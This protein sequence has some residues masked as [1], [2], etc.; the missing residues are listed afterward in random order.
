MANIFNFMSCKYAPTVAEGLEE[1]FEG[2]N[3]PEDFFKLV[4]KVREAVEDAGKAF[5]KSRYY[6]DVE[7]LDFLAQGILLMEACNFLAKHQSPWS[8]DWYELKDRLASAL[9]REGAYWDCSESWGMDCYYF[10]HPDVGQVSIH[11]PDQMVEWGPEARSGQNRIPQEWAGVPRQEYGL[12]LLWDREWRQKM[13]AATDIHKEWVQRLPAIKFFYFNADE[14]G[15]LFSHDE[16]DA[17]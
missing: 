9:I 7:G 12:E 3:A 2:I 10:W 15:Y 4:L 16:E 13:A 17:A 1:Y 11:D 6:I 8:E 5:F 14:E